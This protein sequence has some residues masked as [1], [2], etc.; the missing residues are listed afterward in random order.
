MKVGGFVLLKNTIAIGHTSEVHNTGQATAVGVATYI[1]SE[2]TNVGDKVIASDGTK[3][4]TRVEK[5][6]DDT[7]M[8]NDK[9]F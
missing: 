5:L 1:G 4:T 9:S 8:I 7:Y 3:A 2:P 6:A